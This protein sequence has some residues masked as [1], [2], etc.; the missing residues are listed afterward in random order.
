MACGAF[1]G[2]TSEYLG[3]VATVGWRRKLG[4][5]S[6]SAV[7]VLVACIICA[8]SHPG[9]VRGVGSRSGLCLEYWPVAPGTDRAVNTSCVR[10]GFRSNLMAA[11]SIICS[12]STGS[13][14]PDSGSTTCECRGRRATCVTGGAREVSVD[15]V[16]PLGEKNRKSFCSVSFPDLILSYLNILFLKNLILS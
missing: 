16:P 11:A 15:C 6:E 8:A 14:W 13:T 1:H 5:L 12:L 7:I 10:Q 2:R 9:N 4:C 3:T